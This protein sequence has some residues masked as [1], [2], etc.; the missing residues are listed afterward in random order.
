MISFDHSIT[1]GRNQRFERRDKKEAKDDL[2]YGEKHILSNPSSS[3][4]ILQKLR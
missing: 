2:N 3:L 1:Y 4:L